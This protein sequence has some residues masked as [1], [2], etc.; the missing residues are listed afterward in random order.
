MA[1]AVMRGVFLQM[2][3]Y[4]VHFWL[5]SGYNQPLVTTVS[6]IDTV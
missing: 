4:R 5:I 2:V 3:L 1:A 6:A